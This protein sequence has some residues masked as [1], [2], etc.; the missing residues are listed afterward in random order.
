MARRPLTFLRL[1]G[2]DR[3]GGSP[4]ETRA[5]QPWHVWT[6]PNVIGLVRLALIPVFLFAAL[7]SDTGTEP[8]PDAVFGVIAWGDYAD[9]ITA[10]LTGQYSRFGALLDPAVDRLLVL[11]G[12]IVTWDFDLLPRWLLGVLIARELLMLLAGRVALK[13][14]L[15]IVINW[16]GRASV[17][18]I[19]GGIAAG[20]LGLATLGEILLAVGVSLAWYA[21]WL[22]WRSARAQLRA[23]D[24]APSTSP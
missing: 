3:S 21:T 1:T 10:R 9:G 24:P 4:D 23:R 12:V 17:F 14:S 2:L 13:R 15:D 20:L 8:F 11:S 5:N 16:P 6:A 18:P 19:M 7:S 22:Y